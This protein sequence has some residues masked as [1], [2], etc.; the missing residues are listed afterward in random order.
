MGVELCRTLRR[1]FFLGFGYVIEFRVGRVVCVNRFRVDRGGCSFILARDIF[2]FL[3]GKIR[4]K[5]VG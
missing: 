2:M 5:G 4:G 3:E 1:G